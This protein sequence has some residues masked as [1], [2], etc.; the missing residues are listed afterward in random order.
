MARL[1][2]IIATILIGILLAAGFTASVYD[3]TNTAGTAPYF[4]C[5]SAVA[6]NSANA[7]FVYGLN[8]A[9]GSK[10]ATDSAAGHGGNPNNGVY[11]GTMT[12]SATS[13]LACLRDTGG[14]Y[15]LDGTGAYVHDQAKAPATNTLPEE[16]WFKTSTAAGKLIGLGNSAGV[17][18]RRRDEDHR[19]YFDLYRRPLASGRRDPV[20]QRDDA[21]SRRKSRGQRLHDQ[22]I[23][24]T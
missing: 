21:L 20:E 5:T 4:T 11:V 3:S 17:A 12:S 7:L 13:P 23:A 19:Q 18:P 10:R 6:A 9:S 2:V 1:W 24:G 15:V 16:V 8:E 14:A 22:F